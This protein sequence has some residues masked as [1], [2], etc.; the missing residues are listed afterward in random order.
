MRSAWE[1]PRPRLNAQRRVGT[2]QEVKAVGWVV[3]VWCRAGPTGF[4]ARGRTASRDGRR[5]RIGHVEL[6]AGVV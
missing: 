1:N 2:V 4:V 3:L 5:R 6:G